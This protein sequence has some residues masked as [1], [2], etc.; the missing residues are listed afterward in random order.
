[1]GSLNKNA[2]SRRVATAIAV[3]SFV[4][5]GRVGQTVAD[6]QTTPIAITVAEKTTL[7]NIESTASKNLDTS[8][9]CVSS[10]SAYFQNISFLVD[11]VNPVIASLSNV[12][13]ATS[14]ELL[15]APPRSE[16]SVGVFL[17]DNLSAGAET[18]YRTVSISNKFIGDLKEAVSAAGGDGNTFDSALAFV[19]YHEIGHAV[20][21]HSV[22]KLR[23]NAP[24]FGLPQEFDADQFALDTMT[25]AGIGNTGIDIAK[26]VAGR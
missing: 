20:L 12:S 4:A 13:P 23:G 15:D 24:D 11:K 3:L 8:Q 2:W 19:L 18:L 1:M 22:V 7:A 14:V 25:A 9:N 17:C 5:C 21:N 26:S 10:R 6:R 16:N